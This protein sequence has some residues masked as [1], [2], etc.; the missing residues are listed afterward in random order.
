M[1]SSATAPPQ[2]YTLSLHDAL[3]IWRTSGLLLGFLR[4]P[5]VHHRR[6]PASGRR[7]AAIHGGAQTHCSARRVRLGRREAHGAPDA[8][9]Q[10]PVRSEEHTSELQSHV[11]LVCRLLL[12]RPPRSTLFPYTTLF[13]SGGHPGSSSGSC[14]AQLS[15]IGGRR[16][17]AAAR[18]RSTAGRRRTAQRAGCGWGAARRMARRTRSGKYQFQRPSNAIVAGTS[19]ART[20]VASR[21]IAA[22]RPRPNSCS[23]TKL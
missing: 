4:S 20:I 1:P 9:G 18:R 19:S 22:A 6:P 14:G 23:P 11:N 2:I 7:A 16:R 3:P 10:I 21:K 12:R 8:F 15:T 13:R 17:P 5:I